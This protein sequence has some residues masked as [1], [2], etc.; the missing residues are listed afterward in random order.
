VSNRDK[1]ENLILQVKKLRVESAPHEEVAEFVARAV[2]SGPS[3]VD[4][5]GVLYIQHPMRVSNIV[6]AL[7]SEHSELEAN[8]Y[9]AAWLHDVIEDSEKHFGEQV[10]QDD[11]LVMGFS[12]EVVIAVGL[13]SKEAYYVEDEYLDRIADN[14]IARIVK[15]ADLADNTSPLRRSGLNDKLRDRYTRYWARLLKEGK[16]E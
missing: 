6:A 2:H 14:E 3:A 7:F 11:L 1:I 12:P 5:N 10:T 16:G 15:F 13:L 4:A 8:A 9:S